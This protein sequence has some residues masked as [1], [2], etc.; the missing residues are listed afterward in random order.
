MHSIKATV[1]SLE[2]TTLKRGYT[3]LRGRAASLVGLIYGE[4]LEI[5]VYSALKRA[6]E[7]NDRK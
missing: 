5:P 4:Q 3:D 6:F 1:N 2:R 7:R